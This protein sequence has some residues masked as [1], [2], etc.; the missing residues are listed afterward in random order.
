MAPAVKKKLLLINPCDTYLFI[1]LLE[2]WVVGNP[3]PY[4]LFTLAALTPKEYDTKIINQKLFWLP[5]DFTPGALVG[6]TCLTSAVCEAYQLADKFRKAGSRVVLGGTHVS[7]LPEEALEHADSVVIGEAESIWGQVL[8]D[9]EHNR[10]Q[11]IYSGEALK[12]FFTPVYDY[13][14]RMGPRA[15]GRL[16]IHI[17][18]GCKYHCDFCARISDWLRP[19]KMEQVL[20][21]IKRIHTAKRIFFIRK[22]D[23]MF[24]CDNIYSNPTYAKALFSELVPLKTRWHANCSINIGISCG[25]VPF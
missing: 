15:L 17:D 21:L 12:D 10:L 22:P 14:L 24:R 25:R 8:D 6:I 20:G 2:R 11:K 7:A 9:F 16:G 18:R 13:F 1:N 23:I 19:I 4:A 5:K 3:V